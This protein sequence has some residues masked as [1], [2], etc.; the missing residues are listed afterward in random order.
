MN[1]R[2]VISKNSFSG[3][4]RLGGARTLRVDGA[5]ID[6]AFLILFQSGGV[7]NCISSTMTEPVMELGILFP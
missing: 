2:T 7:S 4:L 3:S 5:T 6:Y 1:A